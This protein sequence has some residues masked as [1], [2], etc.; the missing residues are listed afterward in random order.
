MLINLDFKKGCRGDNDW[1]RT[2]YSKHRGAVVGILR[3]LHFVISIDESSME[4]GLRSPDMKTLQ[5][6]LMERHGP[7]RQPR[8]SPRYV[9]SVVYHEDTK[10]LEIVIW[11]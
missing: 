1:I 5:T 6:R 11:V 8:S 9:K 10:T 4:P 3:S 7:E 2:T